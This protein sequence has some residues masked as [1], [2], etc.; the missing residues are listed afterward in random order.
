MS[1]DFQ[2]NMY[3]M[4]TRDKDSRVDKTQG[5]GLGLAIVKEMVDLMGGTIECDSALGRGT[6]FTVTL[7]LE[8]VNR[9][10]REILDRMER[11]EEDGNASDPCK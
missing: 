6:E 7:E 5:T 4:F 1:G 10:E 3:Q 8:R 2:Q 11:E 9:Q